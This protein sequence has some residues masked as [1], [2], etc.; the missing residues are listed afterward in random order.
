MLG[1]RAR[2]LSVSLTVALALSACSSSKQR[3]AEPPTSTRPTATTT[4]A[5]ERTTTTSS[6]PA[7]P[8]DPLRGAVTLGIHDRRIDA[9][10]VHG[11]TIRTLVTVFAGRQVENARLMPDHRTIWYSTTQSGPPYCNEVVKLN[12]ETNA[13]VVEA[14]ANDFTLSA[15]GSRLLLVWPKPAP[16]TQSCSERPAITISE[17]DALAVV[18]LRTDTRSSVDVTAYPTAGSGGPY[19]HVWMS[20][21]GDQ[22]VDSS[23]TNDPCTM[24]SISVPT[25]LGAPLVLHGFGSGPQCGCGTLTTAADGVYGIDIG[26]MDHP[27]TRL[28]RYEARDL[29]GPG[30][31]LVSPTDVRLSVVAPTS[32]GVFVLGYP[33]GS[34]T[35]SLYRYTDG[36]LERLTPTS[37]REIFPV[38]PYVAT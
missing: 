27:Q 28:R 17:R 32:A 14:Y 12:L 6:A 19:G 24:R 23:C 29:T 1:S 15:D 16:T 18:D 10:D 2:K 3:A 26:S 11:R 13:R 7:A 9:L 4:S 21:A 33:S 38:V 30:T 5:A 20:A 31:V 22:L 25:P 37:Y 35:A 8:V 36:T 34:P